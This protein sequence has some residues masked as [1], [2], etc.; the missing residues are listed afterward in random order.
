MQGIVILGRSMTETRI[1]L[2]IQHG[3]NRYL[4]QEEPEG[5]DQPPEPW[6]CTLRGRLRQGRQRQVRL[7]V[8]GDRVEF[9]VSAETDRL[10]V[11]EE[12][13]PRDNEIGRLAPSGQRQQ[14]LK[15]VVVANVDRLWVIVSLAAPPLNL[16]FLD[17]ILAAAELQGVAAGIV[18]NKCDLSEARDPAPLLELYSSLGYRALEA[19]AENGAGLADLADALRGDLTA[20]VGLSGVGKSSLLRRLEPGLEITVASVAEKHGHGRHTTSGSRL[21]RL[22]LGAWVAD[23]PGMREFG[24]YDALQQEL[25]AGFVELEARAGDCRFRDCRHRS[26]PKCAVRAAVDS[27]EVAGS[28]Y[29]SYLALL[30]ELPERERDLPGQRSQ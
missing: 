30:E 24:L 18:F 2:V 15:Q 17:R 6:A 10:G 3:A 28:R 29:E 20:F 13:R 16:R 11:I 1:G 8:I 23:T 7:A 5:C 4:V 19:S 22:G 12:V 14:R 27:G 21:Y 25:S 26:E 9:S